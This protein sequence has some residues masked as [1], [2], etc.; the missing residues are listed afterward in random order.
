MKIP[1]HSE[2][3]SVKEG[4]VQRCPYCGN[5]VIGSADEKGFHPDSH[6]CYREVVDGEFNLRNW[7]EG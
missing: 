5:L 4:P 2:T 6:F 7:R 1:K 3:S